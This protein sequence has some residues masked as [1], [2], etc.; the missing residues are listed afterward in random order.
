MVSVLSEGA[1]FEGV[2]LVIWTPGKIRKSSSKR[3]SFTSV[4]VGLA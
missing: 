3:D 4:A 1:I 2:G